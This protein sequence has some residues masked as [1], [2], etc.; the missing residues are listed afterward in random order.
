LRAEELIIG[1]KAEIFCKRRKPDF[2][3]FE[4]SSVG[5]NPEKAPGQARNKNRRSTKMS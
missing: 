3:A 2:K 5:N 4:D 1:L